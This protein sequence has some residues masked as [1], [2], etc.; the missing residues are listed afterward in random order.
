MLVGDDTASN[1][2]HGSQK[3]GRRKRIV[4]GM[5]YSIRMVGIEAYPTKEHSEG[6]I[7]EE[8]YN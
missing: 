2:Q 6:H 3:K 5:F 4:G 7:R 1:I 8:E